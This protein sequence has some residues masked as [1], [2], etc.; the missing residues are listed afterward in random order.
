MTPLSVSVEEERNP[1]LSLLPVCIFCQI[2]AGELP[3]HVVLDEDLVLGFLDVRPLFPGHT[4]LVPK[5]HRET[6]SDLPPDLIGVFFST[7]QRLGRAVETG[8]DAD[9]YLLVINNRVSQSVPHLHL[10]LVPRKFRDGLR[11]FLWPRRPYA[12][13]TEAEEVAS[14][15][16]AA[17]REQG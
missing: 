14:K 2:V 3:S 4:L 1:A 6:L 16:R 15:I 11:G 7:A 9:G 5:Q 12:D 13:E 10:H 17:V 8:M